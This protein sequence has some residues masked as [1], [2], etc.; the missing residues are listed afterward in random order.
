MPSILTYPILDLTTL[1]TLTPFPSNDSPPT[2]LLRCT[3]G[4]LDKFSAAREH[5]AEASSA[6]AVSAAAAAAEMSERAARI[7][8]DVSLKAPVIIVPQNSRSNNALLIDLGHIAVG[9]HFENTGRYNAQGL[10]GVIDHM[11]V[12]LSAIKLSK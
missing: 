4:F 2:I 3:Q 1:T 8:L 6:A 7:S 12:E 5:L 9:N 11:K 10:P